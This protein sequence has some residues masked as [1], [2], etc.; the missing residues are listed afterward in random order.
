MCIPIMTD[1]AEHLFV[2]LMAICMSSLKK[3]SDS[4][5]IFISFFF[6]CFIFVLKIYVFI[7]LFI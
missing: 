7:N 5:P 4:F 2:C 6:L 1:D 3:C